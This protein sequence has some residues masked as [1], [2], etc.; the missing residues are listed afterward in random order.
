MEFGNRN[1]AREESNNIIST[2]P[3][4]IS[5]IHRLDAFN[6]LEKLVNQH[7]NISIALDFNVNITEDKSKY[8]KTQQ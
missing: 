4:T 2:F 3:S 5:N 6:N 1:N 7:S 8:Y